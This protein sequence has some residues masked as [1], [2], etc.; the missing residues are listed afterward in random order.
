MVFLLGIAKLYN[1]GCIG[2]QET[3]KKVKNE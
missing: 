3:V 1:T 2:E